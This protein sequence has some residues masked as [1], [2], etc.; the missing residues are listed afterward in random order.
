MK[1]NPTKTIPVLD[2]KEYELRF[3]ARIVERLLGESDSE[4]WTEARAKE[5]ADNE[6][7]SRPFE[8]HSFM[9]EADPEGAADEALSYW[10]N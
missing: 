6:W 7:A 2:R 4:Q 10:N 1:L 8:E 9:L 3:K 5:A